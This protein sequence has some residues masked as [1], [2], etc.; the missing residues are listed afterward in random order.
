M[1]VRPRSRLPLWRCSPLRLCSQSVYRA[2]RPSALVVIIVVV[3]FPLCLAVVHA[4]AP[5]HTLAVKPAAML[6]LAFIVLAVCR[7]RRVFVLHIVAVLGH[8]A[9]RGLL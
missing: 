4:T 3:C 1:A 5:I 8:P 9:P 7:G 6:V 2:D